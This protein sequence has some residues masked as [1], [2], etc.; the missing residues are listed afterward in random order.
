MDLDGT[1]GDYGDVYGE[2]ITCRESCA[3]FDFSFIARGCVS[4]PGAL[5]TLNRFQG[6]CLADLRPGQIRYALRTDDEGIVEA[7]LT[8]WCLTNGVYEVMSGRRRDIT[9]LA[10]CRTLDTRI[11]DVSEQTAIFAIQGPDSMVAL[12][13]LTDLSRLAKLDYFAH[14]ECELAGVACRVGRLGYTGEKG[15]EIV[16]S[17]EHREELWRILSG[18]ARRAGFSAADCLRIEAGFILFTNECRAS[19]NASE[20][21]LAKFGAAPSQVARKRLVCFQARTAERPVRW[22]PEE[23]NVRSPSVGTITVTSACH[24]VVENRTIGLGFVQPSDAY[25]GNSV[26]D[27]SHLFQNVSLVNLPIYDFQKRRPRAKWSIPGHT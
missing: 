22:R 18:R 23:A 14:D 15:F 1:I 25:P 10:Q 12:D 7:D 13:G 24:S 3:L 16:L 9:D 19:A 5:A 8:V 4:G 20:L 27:P 11:E 26:R 2:A 6:R 17:I 21:G